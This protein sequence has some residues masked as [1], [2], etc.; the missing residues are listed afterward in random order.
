MSESKENVLVV[1]RCRPFSEN[2]SAAGHSRVCDID[3][4]TAIIKM[5]NPNVDGDIKTFSFDATFDEQ[6]TQVL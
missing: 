3:T 5:T 4:S 1:V 6:S 2:E